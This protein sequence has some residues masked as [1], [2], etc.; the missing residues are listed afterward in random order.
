MPEI[1]IINESNQSPLTSEK[2]F[3]IIMIAKIF[4]QEGTG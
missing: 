1:V 4:I 3:T 2:K